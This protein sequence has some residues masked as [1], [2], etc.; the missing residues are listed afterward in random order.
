V[1]R[2]IDFLLKFADGF[3]PAAFVT[4]YLNTNYFNY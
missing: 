1:L 2:E 4:N 3:K